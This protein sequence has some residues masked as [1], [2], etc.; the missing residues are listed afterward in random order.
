[1][2]VT[3][4]VSVPPTYCGVMVAVKVTERPLLEGLRLETTVV[5]VVAAFTVWSSTEEVLP[6]QFES[7][8]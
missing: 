4:P 6:W 1:M 3:V 5:V 7:P 8:L 2:N